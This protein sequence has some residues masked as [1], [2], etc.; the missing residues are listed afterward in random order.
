MGE[1]ALSFITK[2]KSAIHVLRMINDF[3]DQLKAG[4]KQPVFDPKKFPEL[5]SEA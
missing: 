5:D 2:N 1:N 4:I 3:G